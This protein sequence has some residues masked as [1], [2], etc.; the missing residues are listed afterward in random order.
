MNTE[1][2]SQT[3]GDNEQHTLRTEE[4]LLN[5]L[6]AS[7]P[8]KPQ[9]PISVT[10]IVVAIIICVGVLLYAVFDK[11]DEFA[12]VPTPTANPHGVPVD[13]SELNSK[14]LQ[15]QKEI[16]SLE[17]VLETFPE[18]DLAMLHLA[19]RYY[20]TENWTKAMPLYGGY[21][22]AHPENVNARVD[23]AF[24]IAQSTGDFSRAVAEIEKGL[25]HDPK[26]INALF[27]AGILSLRANMNNKARA[28]KTARVYFS[29]AQAIAKTE[30]P[31]MASQIEEIL[32]EMENVEKQTQ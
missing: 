22:Q 9:A 5:R 31:H 7:P 11:P 2:T 1:E 20:D 14:R 4:I 32:R 24:V 6:T 13:S 23:F 21:L 25:K 28:L 29:R 26:H 16:D 18:D 8:T 12:D 30:N 17:H 27:N 15:F 10:F 19:N 3:S